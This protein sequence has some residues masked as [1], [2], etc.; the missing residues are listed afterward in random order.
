VYLKSTVAYGTV[1]TTK[2]LHKSR[3]FNLDLE[4]IFSFSSLR[5]C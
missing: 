5:K 2:R 1:L 3:N 4:I